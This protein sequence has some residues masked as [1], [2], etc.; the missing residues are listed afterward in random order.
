MRWASSR[1]R[2][3]RGC[4][5]RA[6]LLPGSGDAL[7]QSRASVERRILGIV[8]D[9]VGELG[10]P[11][12]SRAPSPDDVLDRDLGIG[13]LERVELLLRIEK[14]FGVRL[15]DAVMEEASTPRDLAKAVQE[16][17]LGGVE[18]AYEPA[19]LPGAGVPAPASA[20][21]LLDVLAWHAEAHPDRAHILLRQE[22][23]GERA[24]TY[25]DVWRGAQA[26]AAGLR[27][28]RKS[29]RLN[30]SHIQKSRMPSSA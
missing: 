30:S 25:G 8:A 22:D 14:A 19:R 24:I 27:R 3:P 16:S 13:S 2:W 4:G 26:V 9:L 23:G 5:R 21:T 6:S 1:A 20:D 7:I 29:T 12:A 18:A 11:A 10:G 15:P 17:G 28:D